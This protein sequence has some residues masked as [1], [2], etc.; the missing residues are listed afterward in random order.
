IIGD[1]KIQPDSIKLEI[2]ESMMADNVERAIDVLLQLKSLGIKLGMDDFG[3]G[4]SSLSYLS[5][6]PIDTLKIDRSFVNTMHQVNSDLEVVRTIINLGHNL[7]MDII[8]EGVEHQEQLTT[9]ANLSCEYAQGFF[10]SKPL[11]SDAATELLL[12]EPCWQSS[13]LCSLTIRR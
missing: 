8:A 3:T 4:Y 13:H 2:T 12:A 1:L 5:R 10:M 11:A 6:F 9:L 7:G